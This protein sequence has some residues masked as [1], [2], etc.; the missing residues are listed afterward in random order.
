MLVV[1]PHCPACGALTLG[2]GPNATA[3]DEAVLADLDLGGA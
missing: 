2:Y 1:E 3:D